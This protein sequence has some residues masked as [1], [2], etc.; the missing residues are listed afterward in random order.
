MM[1]VKMKETN[2]EGRGPEMKMEASCSWP[3][4]LARG[5]AAKSCRFWLVF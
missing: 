2:P 5:S 3:C 4:S 1:V